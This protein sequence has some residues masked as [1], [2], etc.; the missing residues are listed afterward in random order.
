MDM[1]TI[2]KNTTAYIGK[3]LERYDNVDILIENDRIAKIGKNIRSKKA[4]KLDGKEFFITP[5]FVNAHFHPSQQFNR[6]LG[7]GLSHAKQMDL[8]HSMSKIKRPSDRFWM[9]YI[10]V[11]EG[12]KAGTTCFYSVGSEIETQAK[13]YKDL[14][15]RAACTLVPKDI[16]AKEKKS[17]TRAI[18]WETEERIKRA[19]ELHNKYHSDLVRVHFGVVNVRYCSDQ[20]IKGMLNLAEKYDVYFHMHAAEGDVY[21]N[22]VKER[23]GHRP[24]EHLHKIGALNH[25]V[26]M[27][28]MTKLTKKEIG[29]LAKAKAHVVH[30]PRAN[31]YV[32]AGICPVKDLMDSGVNVALASDA[33]INNNSNEVRGDAHAAFDKIADKY[34]KADLIDYLDLFKMLTINGAKAMGLEEDIGTIDVGKKADLVLWNK[35]D[36]PFIPGFNHLADLIFTDSCKAHTVY[37]NGKK[38][39]SNYKAA[40]MNEEALKKKV[41]QIGKRY[42]SLFEKKVS[43]HL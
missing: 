10:A 43:K 6:A 33:A 8:L 19:E 23:T 5:G 14:G 13:V 15:I 24:V 4:K 39:L 20:L 28:H 40:M 12:L 16:V 1:E 41:R 25:R 11:L 21:V 17:A 3:K 29:Y 30:C 42:Y 32:A 22:A 18:T 31:A 35:N 38:V 27:A 7:V 36:L 2:I 34:E 9:S 37:V 26:S